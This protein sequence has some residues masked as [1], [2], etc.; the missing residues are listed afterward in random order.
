MSDYKD[1]GYDLTGY[2]NLG[3]CIGGG[4]FGDVHMGE[5]FGCPPSMQTSVDQ[6]PL[7]VIKVIRLGISTSKEANKMVS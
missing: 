2:V 7:V 1:E 4:G 5:W 3:K 6:L